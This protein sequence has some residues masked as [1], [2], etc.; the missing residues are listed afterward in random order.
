MR[1]APFVCFSNLLNLIL[2]W[3]CKNRPAEKLVFAE[4]FYH[5][6]DHNHTQY[7]FLYLELI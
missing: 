2:D 3:V 6:Y 1:V 7:F 4:M 5:N